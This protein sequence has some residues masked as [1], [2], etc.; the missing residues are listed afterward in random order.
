MKRVWIT[1]MFFGVSLLALGMAMAVLADVPNAPLPPEGATYVGSATCADCHE[2]THSNWSNTLHPIMIQ[3]PIANPEVVIADFSV[4]DE[5]RMIEIDGETRP[6][7][8]DD[9]FFTLGSKYRQRFIMQTDDG[10]NVLP[11]QWS[12]EDSAWQ[13]ANPGDWLNSCAGCH[14]T[15]F[16]VEAQTFVEVGVGC[17]SCHGPA[18]V[19]SDAAE[20]LADDASEE[21]IAEVRDLIVSSVDSAVCGACHTR[22]TSPDGEHGYPVGYVVGGPLDDTMFVPVA[23]TGAEDDVNF[24]PD[25]TEKKH[26]QQYLTWLNSAHGNALETITGNDHARD[27]CLGCHSTDYIMSQEEGYVGEPVTMETVQFSITCVQCHDSHGEA[28]AEDQLVGESY[29]LCVSCHTGTRGGNRPILVGDNVHHPMKEMFEGVSFLDLPENPSPHFDNEDGPVCASC[30]M[31]GTAKSANVGDIPTHTFHV[32]NPVETAEGQPDSCTG[33]HTLEDDPENTPENLAFVIEDVQAD[34]EERLEF[35]N[36]DLA[37]IMEAN[38]DWDSDAEEADKSEEQL[39]A[40]EVG[41]LLSFV[42]SDGSLGFHNP[43]YTDDILSQAEDLID[44]LFDA[45]DL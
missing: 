39:M 38:P 40:E 14:T 18:S 41:T 42:E 13:D 24:W 29:D 36:E 3:D 31:V 23:P 27:F 33:C 15:G 12:V 26:R 21:E 5:A 45:L 19:H 6:Y 34:T 32:I 37:L 35:L 7:T 30:H 11:G 22:G 8:L 44:E 1:V 9:V 4:G 16:D 17:E 43:D 20:A 10:F 2:T 25:G 28:E